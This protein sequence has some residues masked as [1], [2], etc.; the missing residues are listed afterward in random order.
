MVVQLG[1]E[2]E[3]N[4]RAGRLDR[5]RKAKSLEP[6][7]V[8]ANSDVT[9]AGVALPRTANY[10]SIQYSQSLSRD[11]QVQQQNQIHVQQKSMS[12][13]PEAVPLVGQT[14]FA[15]VGGGHSTWQPP[16]WAIEPRLGVYFLE[17]L[18]DGEVLDKIYLD[19]RRQ[20]F[21]RQLHACDFVLDHQ[22]VSRQHA[23]VVPHKNGR[24]DIFLQSSL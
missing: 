2:E 20:I 13:A 12:V 16:D 19:K 23:A 14:S 17:V 7:S 10:V 24:S 4:V 1:V 5:F 3:R 8:A 15:Q 6:F 22:S 9:T 11:K 21:G 18:K